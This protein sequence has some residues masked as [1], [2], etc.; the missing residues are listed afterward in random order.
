MEI[1]RC[2]DRHIFYASKKGLSRTFLVVLG[3][4][5]YGHFTSIPLP[6]SC[7]GYWELTLASHL[8]RKRSRRATTWSSLWEAASPTAY[9][10]S[11]VSCRDAGQKALALLLSA[12]G[13]RLSVRTLHRLQSWG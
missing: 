8:S 4:P 11:S 9:E 12:T 10:R 1:E 13:Y 3:R 6:P 5:N 7:T 2:L